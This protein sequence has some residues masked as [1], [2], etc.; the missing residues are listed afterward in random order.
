MK[1]RLF[2]KLALPLLLM[3]FLV[4]L[5]VDAYV[6][7]AL[8]R[9]YLETAFER[10]EAVGR[11]AEARPAAA[12]A[13]ADLREWIAWAASGG[14]R[15]TLIAPDGEVLADS[16]SDPARMENHAGRP[17][18]ADALRAGTGRAVRRSGTLGHELVY[19]A[20][21]VRTADGTPVILR[22]ALPVERLQDALAGFRRGLW[23]VSAAVLLAGAAV[24]LFFFG[25]LSTR[26]ERLKE[27]SR[28]VAEGDFRPLPPERARDELGELAAGLNR[29]AAELD[30]MVRTLTEERNQSAAILASMTEGV[31]V[32][33]A[34]Q[35][36][37]FCNAAFERTLGI[38]GG[39]C[40]GRPM[41]EAIPHADLLELVRKALLAGETVRGELVAGSLRTRSYSAVA[42]P[43]RTAGDKAG[44][45]VVLHDISELRRLERAR[46]DFVANV[47]HEFRTPLTAIQGFAETLLEGALADPA[48]SRRFLEIIRSNAVR[49]QRLTDD[50]LELARIEAGKQDLEMLPV[51][52]AA[53]I[54]PCVEA[55]RPRVQEKGLVLE[56]DCPADVP[57]VRGDPGALQE[58]LQN[59]LD[60]AVQYTPGGGRIRIGAAA[61]GP[62]VALTVTDTGIGIP[63]AEQ[64]RIFER[65]YRA[66]PARSRDLGGT[67]LGLSIAKH[68]AEAHGGRIE[69]E[70]EVGAGS[71]FRVIL[72]AA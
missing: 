45:V 23:A 57:P 9:E 48:N 65:F 25:K 10:L 34:G 70:S 38:Q 16:E 39:S 5:A 61:R 2:R 35:K 52:L 37:I 18:V 30:R 24:S 14:A 40:R 1:S 66:D 7:R 19:L 55:V 17:E 58:I 13:P 62:E 31:A 54:A 6:V 72:P 8:R 4:V 53:V 26:I 21:R 44:A 11:M 12:A 20:L 47:S 28:R 33:D 69:V 36:V 22:L 41:V 67:G 51:A 59:L 15:V 43:V 27:F 71:T 42:A 29:T 32:I 60:N 64:E 63:R 56:V 46:R 3:L 68:L 50:L 49:L